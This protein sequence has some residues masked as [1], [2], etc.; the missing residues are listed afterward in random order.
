[1]LVPLISGG[2]LAPAPVWALAA[3]TLPWAVH[4]RSLG[5]DLARITIWAVSVIAATATALA[6]V[7]GDL[8]HGVLW[9]GVIGA[10]AGAGVAI[11]PS[12]ATW[13]RGGANRRPSSD[14]GGGSPG[15]A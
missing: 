3:V 15:L 11:A 14:G 10:L 6:T 13:V 12:V 1:V 9:T 5:R 4:G 7:H 8:A 2:A